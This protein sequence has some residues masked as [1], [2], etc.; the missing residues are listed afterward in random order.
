[1][2]ILKDYTEQPTC[3]VELNIESVNDVSVKFNICFRS[4][5]SFPAV[6]STILCL[7]EDFLEMLRDLKQLNN[8]Y[9]TMLEHKDPGLCIYHI[10][11][12]GTYYFPN[13]GI[14]VPEKESDLRYKLIFVLDAGEMNLRRATECGPALCLIARMEQINEFANSLIAQVNNV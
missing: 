9:L 6:Q 11:Q 5:H 7:K 4:G 8:T 1:M 12:F 2:A 14:L 3:E 10:P 13:Y